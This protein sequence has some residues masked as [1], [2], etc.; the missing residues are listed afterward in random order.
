MSYYLFILPLFKCNHLKDES[1]LS[2]LIF[3]VR[4]NF[5][6]KYIFDYIPD[7]RTFELGYYEIFFNLDKNI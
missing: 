3:G 2:W 7:A 1:M 6:E 5:Y 4:M